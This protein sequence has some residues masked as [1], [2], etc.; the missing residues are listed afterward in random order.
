ML[1]ESWT[2]H[3]LS[4]LA[5]FYSGGTPSKADD[6]N[7]GGNIPWITV[8]DLKTPRVTE[9]LLTL[10]DEGAGSVRLMPAGTL[11][12]LVRGMGLFKGLPLAIS[13]QRA[14][15]NQDIK[16]LVPKPGVDAEFLAFALTAHKDQI[17]QLVEHAGHGTGRLDTERLKAFP[18]AL[19]PVHE[20]KRISE[21]LRSWDQA[22]AEYERLRNARDLQFRTLRG[23]ILGGLG[24]SCG[25]KKL[26]QISARVRSKSDGGPHPVMAIS[27]KSGFV[28]QSDKYSRD[29]AGKSVAN[30]TLLKEGDFAYNKGNSLSYP[31]G[32]I[33]SLSEASALV[34]N[35]YYCFHLNEDLNPRFYEHFFAAGALNRQLAKMISSG[36]RGNGLLNLSAEDFFDCEVPVP[37][38]KQQDAIARALDTAAHEIE[39]LTKLLERLRAQK[40]GLMQKLLAG[41]LLASAM[42]KEEIGV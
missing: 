38:R 19:P 33:F 2:V 20:Q 18:L 32:C 8:R 10:T 12:I 5:D 39:L 26:K 22:I 27:A 9:T 36:V 3:E 25:K 7:W 15:F 6:A 24:E 17:L 23:D 29:M 13:E 30:Y 40:H 14:T 16:G 42:D 31:Q 35:V 21:I 28:L 4:D 11:Y 37:T 34:P 1:P 41:E